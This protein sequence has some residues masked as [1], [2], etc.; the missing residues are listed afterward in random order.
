VVYPD[1][2]IESIADLRHFSLDRDLNAIAKEVNFDCGSFVRYSLAIDDGVVTSATFSSNGCGFMLAAADILADHVTGQGLR[3]LHGLEEGHLHEYIAGRTGEVPAGRGKCIN[4][5]IS[6]L[7]EAF[8]HYRSTR[9]EEFRGEKALICTCFG[10]TEETID[11]LLQNA[12][13]ETV[14][15]VTR[16]CRAGAGCGSCTM[17]IQEMLDNRFGG[18]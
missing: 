16:L 17:M 7:H 13:V 11:A 4:T 8:A 10:V 9:I 15:D 2:I 3:E 6:A 12:D 1:S 14:E 18:A 5:C